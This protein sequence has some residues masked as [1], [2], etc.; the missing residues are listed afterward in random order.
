MSAILGLHTTNVARLAEGSSLRS[1]SSKRISVHPD[2]NS[3]LVF[4]TDP[5][6]LAVERYKLLRRRL[7]TLHPRGGVVLITSP[8]PG[9]GKTL[10]SVNLAWS[11]AEVG[12]STCLV[13]LDFRAPGVSRALNHTFEDG[14]VE[15]VLEG[16]AKVQD[17]IRQI[18]EPPLHVLG[19]K[20]RLLLP[21]H[22]L[23]SQALATMIADLRSMFQWVVLDFAP[24]IPMA[25]VSE[26]VPQVDGVI[27]VARVG[28]TERTMLAPAIELIHSKLWG[29]VAN[30]CPLDGSAYYGYYGDRKG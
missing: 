30:D 14:G 1:S 27:M 17:L 11:L 3:R 10:T 7:C 28:K 29:V 5:A 8:N 9:E 25:D 2:R 13:D 20:N 15:E 16:Q 4:L 24:V 18:G 12:Q 21:G 19:I 26:V 6:G 23:S 22:L